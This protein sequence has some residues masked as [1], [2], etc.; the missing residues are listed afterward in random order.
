MYEGERRIPPEF[1]GYRL[2]RL[3]GQGGM[4][5][6]YL[7]HDTLLE[8]PVAIKFISA[9]DPGSEARLRFLVEAR[10][11][12]RLQHPCVVAVYRAGEINGFPYLVSEYVEGESLDRMAIPIPWHEALRIGHDLARGLAMAHRYD[13]VHR[14]IKP[15]NVMLARDGT[16]KLLDFGIARLLGPPVGSVLLVEPPESHRL[17]SVTVE[18]RENATRGPDRKSLRETVAVRVPDQSDSDSIDL[19]PDL[20]G[21]KCEGHLTRPGSALGT[22]AYMAPEVWLGEP[23]GFQ[24]DVYSLGALLYGLCAGHPPHEAETLDLLRER[25]LHHD[26]KSLTDLLPDMDQAFSAIVARCLSREPGERHASANEVRAAL[27][28]LLDPQA[29][30]ILPEGNPYRGL[31]AF[32]SSH[33]AL[34]F[35]RDSETRS[36][37]ERLA[38]DPVVLVSGDSGVG[39]SSLCR[40][41]VL[42][43]LSNWLPGDRTWMVASMVPGR[44]PVVSLC[45]VLGS[46]EHLSEESLAAAIADGVSTFGRELRRMLGPGRGLVFFVDQ[47]EEI[48]TFA[49][50]EEAE[51]MTDLLVWIGTQAPGIKL[52]ASVR[53]D[54]LGRLAGFHA[55]GDLLSRWLYFV[56]PL[57]RERVR[58][59]V[60]GPARAKGVSFESGEMVDTLVESTVAAEG[61]LPLLQFALE[62]LWEARDRSRNVIPSG[63]LDALG[64]VGGAL[65][66]YADDLLSRLRPRQQD[67]AHSLFLRLVSAGGTRVRRLRDDLVGNDPE[68]SST[69]DALVQGRLVVARDTTAGPGYEIAHEALLEGWGTMTRWLAADK[70]HRVIR[71]RI[72]AARLE[73]DRLGRSTDALWSR[74]QIEEARTIDAES[75]PAPDAAFLETS[76]RRVKRKRWI[77]RLSIVAV[78][79]SLGLTYGGV[80][81]N[82]HLELTAK[83][84]A[85]ATAGRQWFNEARSA[86]TLVQRLE[87]EAF[88]LFDRPDG[89]AAEEVWTHVLAA[90]SDTR[91][92]LTRACGELEPALSLDPSRTD[93]RA[94]FADI[95]FERARFADDRHDDDTRDEVL[96]RLALYDD[97]GVRLKEWLAPASLTLDMQPGGASLTLERYVRDDSGREA[98]RKVEAPAAAPFTDLRLPPG[99]YRLT[100]EMPSFARTVY[101]FTLKRGEV[102]DLTIGL[103]GADNVP[104]G[105]VFVPEGRFIY[106]SGD[107]DSVRKGFFHTVPM[108]EVRTGPFLIARHET[109]FAQWIEFL[110]SLPPDQRARRLPSVHVGGFEGALTL[111]EGTGGRW[112]LSIKPTAR[113]YTVVSGE[114]LQY[115]GRDRRESQDWLLMPVVGIRA[116]D[117]EAYASWLGT[118][119]MVPGARLCTEMEW[120]RAAR[121]ADSRTYPHGFQLSGDDTNIDLTYGKEPPA[122]GPDEVGSH[123]ASDSPFGLADMA[124]NVWEWTVSSQEAKGHA[125]RGGSFYFDTNSARVYSRETPEPSFRDVSVGV[126]ICADAPP[127]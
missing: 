6:V 34:F 109:T 12:A 82:A 47:F 68:A 105:F 20:A 2:D 19:F 28:H 5:R 21:I 52:L 99:S 54:F 77:S 73:W 81:L 74:Q 27:A 86:I 15:A 75:L 51:V 70:D 11:I 61:G 22:P 29:T 44:N 118:S 3:L 80:R 36:V 78:V 24:A 96:S 94:L 7:G 103:T 79:L 124:G 66:L 90:R 114:R 116:A 127:R 35:G 106:G 69:L 31:K 57:T 100:F 10:A 121:G 49:D 93:I 50:P 76:R 59:A 67:L 111:K 89:K 1:D 115:A 14:D 97:G 8:R 91:K 113:S 110:E 17:S 125:A 48:V 16:V 4:G 120:E 107:E 42:P 60:V 98:L 56:R 43:R 53:G 64:G 9:R 63:A 95:L 101:P 92:A 104:D 62:K 25:V 119:G 108:H 55:L 23:A 117:A 32:D 30:D 102:L 85:H 45:S 83:V 112:T 65:S 87:K 37:L 71:D 84:D 33:S 26:A 39:K 72:L 38:T 123:P 122:M 88:E 58:E 13:V 41:G 46:M 40:A 18:E 126:R